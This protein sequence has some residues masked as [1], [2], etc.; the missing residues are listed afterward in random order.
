MVKTP[1]SDGV[2]YTARL[3]RTANPSR[4]TADAIAVRDGRILAVGNIDDCRSWGIDNV[5]TQFADKVLVPGFVEGHTHIFA[6]MFSSLTYTG[7]HP[8]PLANGSV[9]PGVRSNAELIARL[10]AVDETLEMGKP[11]VAG[12][13]DPIFLAEE[14]LT[15]HHLDE[16]ST[17]R[18]IFVLHANAH[19]ATVNSALLNKYSITTSSAPG[20]VRDD[21]GEP[22]GELQEPAAMSL[23]RDEF[24]AWISSAMSDE[25]MANFGALMRNCGI[26]TATDLSSQCAINDTVFDKFLQMTSDPAYPVRIVSAHHINSR[27][28][29]GSEIADKI[30]SLTARTN[31]KLLFPIVKL[32]LDG[33][34][35]G[36]TAMIS[37]PGVFDGTDHGQFL[38]APEQVVELLRP[39]HAAGIGIH[40]HCNGDLTSGVFI[41]A[42]EQLVREHAWLDHRHTITHAQMITP[43]QMRK[44]R[45]LGMC[46][47]FFANH[48][49]FWGDQHHDITVGPDRAHSINPC[50][51]ADRIGLS[52]SFHSDAPVT[53][54]GHLHT[55][56]AAVNRVTPSGRTLGPNERISVD[57]AFHAA[58]IDAAYQLHLDHLV[59]SLEVGKLADIAVLDD[60]PYTVDPMSIRDIGVWGTMLGGVVHRASTANP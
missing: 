7:W 2:V 53:P 21:T 14:R 9:A 51:S 50:G 18:P 13:F 37:W 45:N 43:A 49:W 16:V 42:V 5:N 29:T 58:T 34:I 35:Q 19:L 6:D 39:F 28:T 41:D 24:R 12:G 56:W 55:M 54:P 38:V 44:A 26:T 20:V 3:I 4:P 60:D 48:L 59:G 52:Y 23:A 22:N 8:R 36:F 11:L 1:H 32:V 57:R 10:R 40:V 30:R 47:N 31:D 15:R 46:A 25:A 33:S 27:P 17:T